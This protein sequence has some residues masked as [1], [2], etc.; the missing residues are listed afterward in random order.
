MAPKGAVAEAEWPQLKV[1]D[2]TLANPVC[3]PV[4]PPVLA[5]GEMPQTA[6]LVLSGRKAP[7]ITT[8]GSYSLSVSTLSCCFILRTGKNCQVIV[9]QTSDRNEIMFFS[10]F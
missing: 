7:E 10:I 6:M 2:N 1:A 8:G 5:A 9:W 4:I 3:I